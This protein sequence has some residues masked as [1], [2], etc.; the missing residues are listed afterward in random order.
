MLMGQSTEVVETMA[1]NYGFP[2]SKIINLGYTTP[3]T[4]FE[5][6]LSVTKNSST[7]IAIGNMGGRGAETSEFFEN[8]SSVNND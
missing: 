8:R 3:S 1:V 7:I 5:K 4:V 2:K 6:V